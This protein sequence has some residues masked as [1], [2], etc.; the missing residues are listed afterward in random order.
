MGEKF[1]ELL[2][3]LREDRK[4]TLRDVEQKTRI[5]NA[6]LSQVERGERNIPTLKIL[7]KLAEVYGVPVSFFTDK[8]EEIFKEEKNETNEKLPAPDTEFICRGYKN[9]SEANKGALKKF[10]NHLQNEDND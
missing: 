9:L 1:G 5:S 6:Y 7:R 2:K 3:R 4:M 8:A 10:L